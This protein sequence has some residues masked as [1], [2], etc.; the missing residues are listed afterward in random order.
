[1]LIQQLINGL[2]LGGAYALVA[3]GATPRR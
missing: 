2:M 1:M 3:I